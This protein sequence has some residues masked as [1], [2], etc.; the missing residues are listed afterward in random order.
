MACRSTARASSA[1]A[2]PTSATS[3]TTASRRRCD[4]LERLARRG[5]H[6]RRPRPPCPGSERLARTATSV[7][8]RR[9]RPSPTWTI[10]VDPDRPRRRRL[11]RDRRGGPRRLRHPGRLPPAGH[12]RRQRRRAVAAVHVPRR[13][14]RAHVR[15]T[16]G[17]TAP[18]TRPAEAGHE[19]TYAAPLPAYGRRPGGLRTRRL[20]STGRA[21]RAPRPPSCGTAAAAGRCRRPRDDIVLVHDPELLLALPWPGRASAWSGT[22]TRTPRPRCPTRP[23]LPPGSRP[24]VCAVIVARRAMGRAP[25]ALLLAEHAYAD[26]FRVRHP[27]VPN[28]PLVPAAGRPPVTTASSTSAGFRLR[29]ARSSLASADGWSQAGSVEVIGA[30][31]ADC[32]E[33][34]RRPKRRGVVTRTGFLPNE[35]AL[36][37]LDGALAGLSLLH[38]HPNYRHSLPTKVAGVPGRRRPRHHHAVAGGRRRSSKARI[39]HGG[40]VRGSRGRVSAVL[41]L[42]EDRHRARQFGRGGR[43]AAEAAVLGRRRAGDFVAEIERGRAGADRV[44]GRRPEVDGGVRTA[45]VPPTNVTRAVRS[46]V[47]RPVQHGRGPAGVVA[48]DEQHG[49]RR[50]WRPQGRRRGHRAS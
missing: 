35:Q 11:R 18:D 8:R 5:A 48:V 19:V 37:R 27:V 7:V 31:D 15:W 9:R 22:S 30:V 10:A 24:A 41:S 39:R 38:D 34:S 6:D 32:A 43:R 12:R 1:S 20:P 17:S 4:V 45:P 3:P 26:R 42:A 21:C 33:E 50:P 36:G 49:A 28:L 29:G 47:R 14:R 25:S 46:R 40:P 2:W 13:H 23:W 44:V 16:R